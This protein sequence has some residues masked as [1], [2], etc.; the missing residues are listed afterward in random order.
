MFSCSFAVWMGSLKACAGRSTVYSNPYRDNALSPRLPS[1]GD[2][3]LE[4][5]SWKIRDQ[6]GWCLGFSWF[7]P[8][9]PTLKLFFRPRVGWNVESVRHNP[10]LWLLPLPHLHRSSVIPGGADW[11]GSQR[12]PV[13]ICGG[14]SIRQSSSLTSRV[15][16]L[17]NLRSE[18]AKV[19]TSG[20]QAL[21]FPFICLPQAKGKQTPKLGL[22]V[23]PC[24]ELG[25]KK[26]LHLIEKKLL[27]A[28]IVKSFYCD[29]RTFPY[30][31]IL[32]VI[33]V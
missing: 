29:R 18:P 2:T 14:L 7:L 4:L 23:L 31:C 13:S 12:S 33:P 16:A 24:G 8:T 17:K 15:L 32:S 26:F 9:P 3:G 30:A 28:Y 11:K 20:S 22:R 27:S 5:L 21:Q 6:D 25:K 1:W 10:L 19:F